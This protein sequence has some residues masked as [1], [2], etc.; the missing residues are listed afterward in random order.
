MLTFF[1]LVSTKRMKVDTD[2][3][4]PPLRIRVTYDEPLGEKLK[5]SSE[6]RKI[7]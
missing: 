6:Q 7:W 4:R 5:V 3:C 1:V 2:G